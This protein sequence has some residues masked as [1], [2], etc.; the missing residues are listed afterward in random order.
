MSDSHRELVERLFAEALEQPDG[1]RRAWLEAQR[2]AVDPTALNEAQALL[3]ADRHTGDLFENLVAR[4]LQDWAA[5]GDDEG[6]R[7]GPYRLLREIGRGGMSVVYLAERDDAAYRQQVAV[8]LIRRG[9]DTA[10][11]RARFRRERQI[12]ANLNHPHIAKVLDGGESPEG[13]PYIVMEHIEGR[14]LDRYCDEKALSPSDRIG[15]F[16]KICEAV[17]YAHRQLVIHRDLKPDNVLIDGAGEPKLLDFGIA[18]LLDPA[19]DDPEAPAT[20]LGQR[21]LT[22]AYASP[23]QTLGRAMTTASDVYSLG[24]LLYRLLTGRRPLEITGANPQSWLELAQRAEP[25]KPSQAAAE[26]PEPGDGL[27][28]EQRARRLRGDL[29]SIILKAMRKEP[30]QRYRS[31]AALAADLKRYL[32][33]RPVSARR[34]ATAYYAGKFLKRHWLGAASVAIAVVA[35]ALALTTMFWQTRRAEAARQ[36]AEAA[37]AQEEKERKHAEDNLDLLREMFRQAKYEESKGAPITAKELLDRGMAII[38]ASDGRP[39]T[40]ANLLRE[41]GFL[42]ENLG[43]YGEAEEAYRKALQKYWRL[44]RGDHPD[45]AA[46]H[47]LIGRA[48]ARRGEYD[49]ASRAF[50]ESLEMYE[51]LFG[52]NHTSVAGN[53][54]NLALT[55]HDQGRLEAAEAAYRQALDLDIRLHGEDH[56]WTAVTKSNLALLLYD[57]GA[58]DDAERLIR[59]VLAFQRAEVGPLD[60]ALADSIR[61]LGLIL[62]AEGR[63]EE[64]EDLIQEALAIQERLS[65]TD[66][67]TTARLRANLAAVWRDQGRYEEAAAL[68]ESALATQTQFL[69]A[70]HVET[71]MTRAAEGWLWLDTGRPMAAEAA[72][73]A[74]LWALREALSEEVFLKGPAMLGLGAA[75]AQ[76]WACACATPY[77]ERG[78]TLAPASHPRA[79]TARDALAHCRAATPP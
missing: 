60:D 40:A 51:R 52:R 17:D 22:P 65:G 7:L 10:E 47:N 58:Y 71:A 46:L 4:E 15:L 49:A 53:L 54:N 38:A 18:K 70:I 73:E 29:D 43:F 37:R 78:L 63:P 24:A 61:Q 6:R 19:F 57:K 28:R 66:H 41:V 9:M 34:G 74:S 32:T 44:H 64:A 75:L 27:A 72:F 50:R 16:V 35:I 25:A 12:L 45:I 59:E 5:G 42:Y 30:E 31:A 26:A 55:F 48:L 56:E 1:T 20:V 39:E 79:E 3:E 69:G 68:F 2:A 62:Q 14:P 11:T 8:K 21:P 33:D 77:L 67:P 13:L 36:R 23:E 76:Q